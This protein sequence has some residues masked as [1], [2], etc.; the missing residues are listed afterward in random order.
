MA[1]NHLIAQS[2]QNDPEER[3]DFGRDE[4][5]LREVKLPLANSP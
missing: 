4:R 1:V 2:S 3:F 5:Q